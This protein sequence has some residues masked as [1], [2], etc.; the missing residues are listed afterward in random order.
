[1]LRRLRE[2]KLRGDLRWDLSSDALAM[3]DEVRCER[4][5][6]DAAAFRGQNGEGFFLETW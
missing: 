5:F 6:R 3:G 4:G 2:A 1:M